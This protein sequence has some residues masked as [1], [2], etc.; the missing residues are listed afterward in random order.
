[1][2]LVLVALGSSLATAQA[3]T[4]KKVQVGLQVLGENP[5]KEMRSRIS[6]S[7]QRVSEKV[8]LRQDLS[9]VK[10]NKEYL[11]YTIQQVFDRVLVGYQVKRVVLQLGV[12]TVVNLDLVPQGQVVEN[13]SLIIVSQNI[14]PTLTRLIEKEKPNLEKVV[15]NA[16]QGLPVDTMNWSQ[17]AL[18]PL[19]EK[20]IAKELPGFRAGIDF[21]WGKDTK[22]I[23]S[24]EPQA[25]LIRQ[26]EVN[27]SSSTLP[28]I[29]LQD[30]RKRAEKQAEIIQG[31]PVIFVQAHLP[32]LNNALQREI[33]SNP[34]VKK[35]GLV[36]TP[37]IKLGEKSEINI[38]IDSN[39]YV[40]SLK[41][42]LSFGSSAPH[43]AEARIHLGAY[44]QPRQEVF[45][46]PVFY[47]NPVKLEWNAG[48]SYQANKKNKVGLRYNFTE[49]EQHAFWEHSLSKGTIK[50]DHNFHNEI[51]EL[52]Y[53]HPLDEYSSISFTNNS[54]GENWFALNGDF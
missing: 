29:F 20:M 8:L 14:S 5:S 44:F 31:L 25:P 2:V 49:T 23:M 6:N 1:M 48:Y 7:I 21:Q 30:W 13:V 35:Y 34:Q 24:L 16:L 45:L 39:K 41:G 18:E 9:K 33:S 52:T 51:N 17:L 3:A 27:I 32:E 42:A 22:I 36:I 11:E 38:G 4:I 53:S 10:E 46:E 47:P 37:E 26:V 12:N 43:E 28:K 15:K 40:L 54:K 19:L 50:I